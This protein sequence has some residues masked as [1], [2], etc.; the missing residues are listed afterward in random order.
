MAGNWKE[1]AVK[2]T[3]ITQE[4]TYEKTIRAASSQGNE[5]RK[6]ET[7]YTAFA[8]D[9]QR[10]KQKTIC[11]TTPQGRQIREQETG[12][13]ANADIADGSDANDASLTTSR[14]IYSP[15]CSC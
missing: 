11:A 9:G 12:R 5:A 15:S 4:I 2:A 8:R 1:E 13:T 10:R 6:Q 14:T 3:N 7:I